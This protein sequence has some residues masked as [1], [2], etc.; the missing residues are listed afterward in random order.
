MDIKVFYY[1][2]TVYE[3]QNIHTAAKKL[4]ISP[5]GLERS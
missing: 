3:E 1:F 5:Q 2:Q 4:Y